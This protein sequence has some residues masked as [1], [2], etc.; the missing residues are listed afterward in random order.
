MG[1]RSENM[2]SPFHGIFSLA[3]YRQHL[4]R[5]SPYPCHTWTL[6]LH[7]E[8]SVICLSAHTFLHIIYFFM[9]LLLPS[10]SLPWG[11]TFTCH[12]IKWWLLSSRRCHTSLDFKRQVSCLFLFTSLKPFVPISLQTFGYIEENAMASPHVSQLL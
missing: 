10:L 2:V 6:L 4:Y 3:L 1:K 5:L 12:L 7:P 8:E 11:H 9:F